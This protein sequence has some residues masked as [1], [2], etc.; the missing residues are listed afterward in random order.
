MG[1]KVAVCI[2]GLGQW[3]EYTWPFVESILKHEPEAT[4]VVVD[5]GSDPP[6]PDKPFVHRI[7]KNF[8]YAE[9]VNLAVKKAG[10]QDW[11]I[12]VNNDVV[13]NGKFIPWLKTRAQRDILYGVHTNHNAQFGEY[14]EGWIFAISKEMWNT[15]GPFDE[16]YMEAAFEDVDYSV[17]AKRAGFSIV[18]T[19]LPFHHFGGKTRHAIEGYKEKRKINREYFLEKFGYVQKG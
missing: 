8:G 6:Y 13:C 18:T 19:P 1:I 10:D 7:D 2:V 15:I 11:Y 17:R 12:I 4:V 5:N 9:G 14:I 16:K 3:E